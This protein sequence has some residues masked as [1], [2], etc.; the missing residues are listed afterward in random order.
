LLSGNAMLGVVEQNKIQSVKG[1]L[2]A[3]GIEQAVVERIL[4]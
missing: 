2:L 1:Q 4:L 3:A